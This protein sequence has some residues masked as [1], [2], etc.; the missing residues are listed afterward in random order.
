MFL[1]H[2]YTKGRLEHWYDQNYDYMRALYPTW[3]SDSLKQLMKPDTAYTILSPSANKGWHEMDAQK[4]LLWQGYPTSWV[5]SDLCGKELYQNMQGRSYIRCINENCSAQD[6]ILDQRFDFI[7]DNKGALWHTLRKWNCQKQVMDLLAHYASMLKDDTS[8]LLID[9]YDHV[10][11]RYWKNLMRFRHK[12]Y[13]M[14]EFYENSTYHEWKT[15]FHKLPP[16]HSIDTS[17]L[18]E[19]ARICIQ[20]MNLVYLNKKEIMNVCES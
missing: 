14:D 19:E 15:S 8:C 1:H 12:E 11:I 18:E 2:S 13:K 7:L 10:S 9:G 20:K 16:F 3:L 5:L 17:N 6:L 4:Q